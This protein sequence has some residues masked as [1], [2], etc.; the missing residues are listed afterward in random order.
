VSAYAYI[1]SK[2]VV[3][4]SPLVPNPAYVRYAYSRNPAN[5]NLININAEAK[6]LPASPIRELALT[7]L[8]GCTPNSMHIESIS[9]ET[10]RGNRGNKFGKVEVAVFDDCGDPISGAVITGTFSGDFAEQFDGTTTNSSGVAVDTTYAQAKNPSYKFC[11]DGVTNG[12]D[13]KPED[14]IETCNSN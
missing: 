4:S 6:E 5:P 9:C 14:N 10:V 1:D 7:P 8:A 12:L 13:Y 2:T 11:V 3:V